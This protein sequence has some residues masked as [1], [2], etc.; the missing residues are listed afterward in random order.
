[1]Q[2]RADGMDLLISMLLLVE[3]MVG[4]VACM[5]VEAMDMVEGVWGIA[6]MVDML[7]AVEI[8]LGEPGL[9]DIITNKSS[10]AVELLE[11]PVMQVEPMA[12]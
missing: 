7:M 2:P 12:M 8:M 10:M 5:V 11:L 9:M 6:E 1:M 3:C 4:E